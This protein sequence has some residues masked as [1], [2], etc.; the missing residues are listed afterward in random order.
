MNRIS[1]DRR[2]VNKAGSNLVSG[3]IHTIRQNYGYWKRF[4]G[5]EATL[6]TWEGKPYRSKQKTFCVKR[7]VSVQEIEY[8]KI[9][10]D[11]AQ[12]KI[13]GIRI[14]EKT[15][16]ENDGFKDEIDFM[17]WF[18]DGNYKSGKMAILHFTDFRY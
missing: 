17:D 18:L 16:G 3:K 6:F 12:L 5:Q 13:N 1:F 9:S 14:N 11:Y 10:C 15:M 8:E 2:F 7:I 4:E